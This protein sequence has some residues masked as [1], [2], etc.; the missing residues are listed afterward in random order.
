MGERGSGDPAIVRLAGE[1]DTSTRDD[2]RLAFQRVCDNPC[3][4]VD[5]TKLSYIDST[6]IGELMRAESRA[7]AKNGKLVIVAR[8]QRIVRVLSIAGLTARMP[9]VDTL[10]SA[11]KALLSPH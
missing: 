8:S 6:V 5:L 3:V 4:I 9:I 2:V 7:A 1:Q 10:D 11:K